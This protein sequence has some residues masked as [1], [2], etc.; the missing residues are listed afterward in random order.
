[1]FLFE[2]THKIVLT[3]IDFVLTI[4]LIVLTFFL[5]EI[6]YKFVLAIIISCSVYSNICSVYI[7][8]CV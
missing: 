5:F 1:L 7:I 8:T 6:T 4:V 2:M 3:I